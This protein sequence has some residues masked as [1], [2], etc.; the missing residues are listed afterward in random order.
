MASM[1]A[2]QLLRGAHLADIASCFSHHCPILAMLY[3]IE[4]TLSTPLR[5]S[6]IHLA[7]SLGW[8][9][10]TTNLTVYQ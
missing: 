9:E 8:R 3:I 7:S 10:D 2:M 5:K 1:K 4:P 6:P